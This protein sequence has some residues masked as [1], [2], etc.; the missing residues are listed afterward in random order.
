MPKKLYIDQCSLSTD[1]AADPAT[2]WR[3]TKLGGTIAGLV[4]DGTVEVWTSPVNVLEIFLCADFDKQNRVLDTA[5]LDLRVRL[6]QALVELSDCRRMAPGFEFLVVRNFLEVLAAEAPAA[7]RSTDFF[8]FALTTNQQVYAGLLAMLAA[9]RTLD[10]PDAIE[11]LLR[12]KITSRLLHSRFAR[13][14]AAFVDA[15]VACATEFRVT[16]DD[17][18]A[19]FDV[20]PL[21]SLRDAIEQNLAQA[22]PM[23]NTVRARLQKNK[24]AVAEAYSAAELGQ[25]LSSIFHRDS[26]LL[27]N[28]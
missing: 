6:A 17:I 25:C 12:S 10:R 1:A 27:M 15:M 16:T 9:L 19:E 24:K 3:K 2:L 18:W 22:T 23:D 14:P 26:F 11:D 13:D 20:Q 28:F 7:I 5:K 8:E 21:Q 4:N